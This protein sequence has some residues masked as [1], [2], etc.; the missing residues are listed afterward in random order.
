MPSTSEKQKRFW[1]YMA[2]DEEARKERG[3]SKET[4]EEWVKADQKADKEKEE[5][6]KKEDKK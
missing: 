3:I 6:K 5:S 4:A 2:H 1:R